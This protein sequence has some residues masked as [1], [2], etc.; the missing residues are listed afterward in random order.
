MKN[1]T[2]LLGLKGWSLQRTQTQGA[3]KVSVLPSRRG[4]N[5]TDIGT[6]GLILRVT[7]AGIKEEAQCGEGLSTDKMA[8]TREV[9]R[10][11]AREFKWE[12]KMPVLHAESS[13]YAVSQQE[14]KDKQ[15]AVDQTQSKVKE[16]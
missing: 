5:A 16:T 13:V 10:W 4:R 8:A 12:E 9:R 1:S 3:E 7:T 11:R 15:P 6:Q 14:R 2:A